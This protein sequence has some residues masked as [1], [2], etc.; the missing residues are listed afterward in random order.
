MPLNIYIFACIPLHTRKL[1]VSLIS[2]LSHIDTNA[3]YFI[4]SSAIVACK[5]VCYRYHVKCLLVNTTI[6]TYYTMES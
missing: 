3:L 4:S 6:T 5:M 2:S 1:N